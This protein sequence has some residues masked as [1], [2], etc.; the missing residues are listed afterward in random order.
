MRG[1]QSSGGSGSRG[2]GRRVYALRRILAALA[3]V[4]LLAL[5]VPQACQAIFGPEED[6]GSR[7]DRGAGAPENAAGAGAADDAEET[8]AEKSDAEKSDA[9][10]SDAEKSDTEKSDTAEGDATDKESGADDEESGSEEV[11]SEDQVAVGGDAEDEEELGEILTETIAEKTVQPEDTTEQGAA[12]SDDASAA[13]TAPTAPDASADEGA[14]SSSTAAPAERPPL[15]PA[16]ERRARSKTGPLASG[17]ASKRIAKPTLGSAE[18]P[19]ARSVSVAKPVIDPVQVS[20][21]KR[22]DVAPAP[23]APVAAAPVAA[24]P[25]AAAPVAVAPVVPAPI[26]NDTAFAAGG[27]VRSVGAGAVAG[28]GGGQFR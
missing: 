26:V 6:A 8:T 16:P 17:P 14:G 20:P 24:A 2:R 7:D 22:I 25:V 1:P 23:A 21:P 28:T 18:P 5:L 4:L 9:E 13:Q 12:T 19:V 15:E 3:L 11:A 27:A 10:K